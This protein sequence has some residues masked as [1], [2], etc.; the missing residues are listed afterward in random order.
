MDRSTSSSLCLDP[1]SLLILVL[2]LSNLWMRFRIANNHFINLKSASTSIRSTSI[3]S[4][5][6]RLR[7]MSS[8]SSTSAQELSSQIE[9]LGDKVRQLKSSKAPAEE[10]KSSVDELLSLKSKLSILNGQDPN[11]TNSKKKVEKFVLKTPKGT[12]DWEPLSM[13]LRAQI[14][15]SVTKVFESH[16]AVTIDTPVFERKE[17]LSGKY[18]ED[19]KLI[20]DLQDQ[21]GELCSL[22]YDLTVSITGGEGDRILR[23]EKGDRT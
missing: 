18:G 21:G 20:Y 12:R 6:S 8:S 10:I 15:D 23:R 1:D 4:L 22:R 19:S 13:R 7:A 11:N 14:F 9:S 16:G 5:P 17:I 3:L 2:S